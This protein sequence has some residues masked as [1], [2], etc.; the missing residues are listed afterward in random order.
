MVLLALAV[1]VPALLT[2][3]ILGIQLDRQARTLFANTLS[4]SLETFS[5][6]LRDNERNLNEGLARA[7]TDNTL[8]ITLELEIKAQ[9]AKYIEAQRQVLRIG[10]LGVYDRDLRVIAFTGDSGVWNGQ[11]RLVASGK[12]GDDCVATQQVEQQFVKC[13]GTMYLVSVVQIDRPQDANLGDGSTRAKA[14]GLLGYLMG[15]APLAGPALISSLQERQINHPLI[16]VDDE[17]VYSNIPWK[18]LPVPSPTYGLVK[19]FDVDQ[20][21]YLGAVRLASVGTQRLTYSAFAPLA[22]LRTALLQSVFT[23]AG[24]GLLLVA[25]TLVAGGFI[26]NRMLQPIRQ[27]R[28]GAALIGGGDLTQRIAVHT[29][30]ELEALANQFNDMAGKLEESYA[31]LEQKVVQRTHELTESLQQQTATADVLKV[32]SRS[33]FDLQMVLDTLVQSAARLC[34]AENVFIFQRDGEVYRLASSYG[35]GPDYRDYMKQQ[36]I[37]LGKG[38]L[39]GRTALTGKVVH[40][41]DILEDPDYVWAE[42]QRRGGFRTMLGVPLLRQSVCV[43]VLAMTRPEPR[44]FAAKQIDLLATFADQAVIAI[45]NV[46]L[47]N[48]IQDKSRQLEIASEHKSQ[49]LANM[50][51]ELRTPLN[52]IIGYSEILQEDFADG[53]QQQ[54]IPDLK[55]IEN[56][57]R[58]LLGLINDIL[59]LSKIEAGRMDVFI[60]EVEITPLL[61][62]VR[63]IIT[64]LTQKNG[65][66]LEFR[67][68][69]GLGSMRTDRT[70]LKQSL[71]NVLSNASK[72]T[73]NGR[74]TLAA[75]RFDAGIPM[76]RFA[77]SDTGIGMNEEQ[78]GRLFQAFSQADASTT[79]K[80]GGT[81]LGLAITRHFCQLLGGE[82]TVTSQPGEGSTFTIALPDSPLAAASVKPDDAPRISGEPGNTITVL[83]V[84]DDPA[85]HELLIAKLKNENY[86]LIHA[87]NGEEALEMAR[88][89][90]PDAITLDVLMPKTDGWAVLTALKADGELCDIPVVMLTVVPDRGLGH[91]LGAVDVLTK[92]VDRAQLT[93]LLHRLLN[94]DGPVLVVEDDA[95][96]REM[97][98][99]TIEKIGL[100]AAEAVNGRS[101]LAWLRDNPAPAIILL[102]LMMPEMDGF[103]FLDAFKENSGW[104]DIPV[105]VL[106]GMSLTLEQRN[107]LLGQVREVIAKS[108][109]THTDISAA[110]R[111]AVRR[112]PA[113]ALAEAVER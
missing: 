91:S 15:G 94:R 24:I 45:E 58:H 82:I 92:P 105:I 17:I 85:A 50:S 90:R 66:T 97:V 89:M 2:C 75:E 54:H 102:D 60:E 1:S 110:I 38:T 32:I 88:R 80:Y 64:P 47:F 36:A 70:K 87:H 79:K 67:V 83:V 100:V 44:P 61:D 68:A 14:S 71:L 56:A 19:E 52:A 39:V 78:L 113:R 51:H 40:I 22:P 25:I 84:D 65:N 55:K 42:S 41:P 18:N 3:L 29:G 6:I 27:L 37:T 13:N 57:G 28:Q 33:T 112:R 109:S 69:P 12:Y 7:A 35:F 48:E 5:L 10:F 73:Q 108:A 59:D 98:R 49:F 31:G 74:L 93:A 81:G 26:T 30:D 62:E 63:S 16:W 96:T 46:R 101:A 4:A 77:V 53:G 23:V 20:T 107:R 86:R 99:H 104:H 34:E 8:Q 95:G 72:F 111:E 43:G 76:V 9:L 11:W 21:A 103:E 106:T